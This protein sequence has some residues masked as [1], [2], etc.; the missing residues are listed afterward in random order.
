MLREV[1]KRDASALRGFLGRHAAV[2]DGQVRVIHHGAQHLEGH[3]LVLA[4]LHDGEGVAVE[5]GR[6]LAVDARHDGNVPA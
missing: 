4:I 3:I 2:D 6:D 1:G 5:F